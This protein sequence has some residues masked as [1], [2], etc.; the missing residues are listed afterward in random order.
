[1]IRDTNFSLRKVS[2]GALSASATIAAKEIKGTPLRGMAVQVVVPATDNSAC[3]T[4]V[5]NVIDGSLSTGTA[6]STITITNTGVH[7]VPFT[8]NSRYVV[9][10]LVVAGGS[11]GF[12]AVEVDIVE[13]PGWAWSRNGGHFSETVPSDS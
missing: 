2:D 5:V 10:D 1:M 9:V 8:T 11:P 13:S 12:G 4:L 7:Y 6:I 3:D